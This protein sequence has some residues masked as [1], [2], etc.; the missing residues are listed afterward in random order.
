[1]KK[2]TKQ[3]IDSIYKDGRF[4]KF[5]NNIMLKIILDCGSP[6]AILY[7]I[8]LM[9]KNNNNPHGCYPTYDTL[10]SECNIGSKA[11]L[12][13][14]LSKLV[15]YGYIKIKS[16]NRSGSSQYY[17]PLAHNSI[18][19]YTEEDYFDIES[20]VRKKGTQN[21]NISNNSLNNLKGYREEYDYED[22]DEKPFD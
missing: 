20:I 18:S 22:I 19:N 9:H 16:G 14:Q 1:M 21:I 2:L 11:T 12:S 10:M 13:S 17:F 8:L 6:C 5:E 3:Q 7:M 4:T 15:E